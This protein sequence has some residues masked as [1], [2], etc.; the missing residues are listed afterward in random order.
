MNQWEAGIYTQSI[1]A[2]TKWGASME[3]GCS[4]TFYNQGKAPRSV[5]KITHPGHRIGHA[6]FNEIHHNRMSRG[7]LWYFH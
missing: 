5:W 4:D 7:L 2:A 3:D 6:F 1:T